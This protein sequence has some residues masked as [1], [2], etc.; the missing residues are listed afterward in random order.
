M[1]PHRCIERNRYIERAVARLLA[2]CA[3]TAVSGLAA[4]Q[5]QAASTGADAPTSASA[6]PGASTSTS[7]SA[8]ASTN[9]TAS[10]NTATGTNTT[11]STNAPPA[12]A[13]GPAPPAASAPASAAPE[14]QLQEVVVTGT[15]I[16]RPAAETAEAITI[17]KSDEL[18]DQGITNVEQALN[19]LT[20]NVPSVNI[21][22]QVGTFSGG[23]TYANLRGLGQERTLV[24]LDGQRLANNA[25]QGNGVDLSGIP[26]SA[27]DSVQVLREGASSLY[28]TDAIAGVI[29][30]IT[31]KNYQGFDIGGTWNRPQEQGGGSYQGDFTFGH[32]DIASDGYNFLWTASY[33]R[34][35]ELQ[36]SARS[37]S[38]PGFDPT[39]GVT[40]TNNPGTF[41]GTVIDSNG[42][43]FQPGFPQCAGNPFLTTALGQCAYRYS[44][45]TDLLPQS[46]NLSS[47]MEITKA[48][49]ANN[50]VQLQYFYTYSTVTAWSGPMF[51]EFPLNPSSPYFPTAASLAGAPCWQGPG[52]PGAT[53]NLTGSPNPVTAVWTD[54]NNARYTGNINR[55]Q[56]ILLTFSGKNYGW[57]Y[58]ATFNWSQNNNDNRNIS[59]IPNEFTPGVPGH[60]PLANPTTG[61]L[62]PLINPFGPQS[63]AGQAAINAS[64][65]PGT[66]LVG[67]DRLWQVRGTASHEL[68]EV[69]NAGSPSTVAFGADFGGERFQSATTPY[70]LIT[71]AA[72]G[73]G[74]SAT[75]GSR[76][77]QA[78]F[79]ELDVPV[80]KAFEVNLSDRWDRY[81][82]FGTTQNG[83]LSLRYQPASFV[84][85]RGTASTGFRA[86]T[87]FQLYSPNFLAASTGGT[88][89]QGNPFCT[90]ATYKPPL[91][92]ATTCNTQGLGL[93]GGNRN[94]TPETSQNF[95]LGVIFSP[96]TDM[97][98]TIDYYRILIENT[99][100]GVP[101]AAIYANPTLFSQ[102]IVPNNAG[103]LTPSIASAAD[104]TPFTAPTCGYITLQ[105]QNTGRV[106]TDGIDLSFQYLQ[107]TPIGTFHEDLEGTSVTQF[108]LQQYTGGPYLNLVGW[109]NTLPPVYRWQHLLRI[110]WDS[111]DGRWG[112]GA[113]NRLY[114]NYIDEF[115]DGAGN[116]RIVGGYSTVDA[117]A[118]YKPIPNLQVLFGVKNISNHLP[119]YTNASE[120]N[121]NFSVGYNTFVVD[122]N[123]RTFYLNVRYTIF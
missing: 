34:Q 75:E 45:A 62:N 29:N 43:Y 14:Q 24:L 36:A 118:S 120:P 25:F 91:W 17:L 123:L 3:I 96:V 95:N 109:F 81:S 61:Q 12:A 105:N 97:G 26:F 119:P 6:P 83:K 54:P 22:S 98:L 104:C 7:A 52:C 49:P 88:M 1:N 114:S 57:D 101:A 53:P 80:T 28:G 121:G 42:N 108:Q 41:P 46:E 116:R 93:S 76:T 63:A 66:Y 74:P 33:N 99:I 72:T 70:N 37:F 60:P 67:T 106:T 85:F 113:L 10:T 4:A 35:D 111:P 23:G 31:K 78:L 39:R 51:Y 44:A 102:Y 50:Q 16:K 100:S 94:L 117:Y 87:L 38:A 68:G 8:P 79:F 71:E 110:D 48:L 21:A 122:P 73:L 77:T 58:D 27:L 5:E 59:G 84:T 103:T 65:V 2:V 56:R 64:Y 89:G 69:L 40:Q 86:P 90:P 32:G 82:D 112:A 107:R 18:R 30:F 47:M 92:T 15:M 13:T 55:Q 19:T 20:Q 11:A 115:P 9:T